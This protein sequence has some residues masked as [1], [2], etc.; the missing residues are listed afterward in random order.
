MASGPVSI[1]TVTGD[2][3]AVSF[4]GGP[5]LIRNRIRWP[6]TKRW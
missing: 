5:P 6:A 1:V 2:G 3:G 4:A